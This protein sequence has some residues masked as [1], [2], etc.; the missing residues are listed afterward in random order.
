MQDS[1]FSYEHTQDF[2]KFRSFKLYLDE[3]KRLGHFL[4]VSAANTPK[5]K[6]VKTMLDYDDRRKVLLSSERFFSA[7]KF[8]E[9]IANFNQNGKIKLSGRYIQLSNQGVAVAII[10]S[11]LLK[12]D[13]ELFDY[14]EK[15]G[16]FVALDAS[17]TGERGLPSFFDR[18]KIY[19]NPSMRWQMLMSVIFRML[20]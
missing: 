16:G 11:P 6:L 12:R 8:S 10:G 5:E 7:R 2:T 18:K 1:F 9:A 13:F 19:Y 17:E 4:L 3:L 20:H 15:A 14:I